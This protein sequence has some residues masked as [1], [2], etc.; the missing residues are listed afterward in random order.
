MHLFITK[1]ENYFTF[2]TTENSGSQPFKDESD[3]KVQL[4]YIKK[5]FGG[6]TVEIV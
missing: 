1:Y 4:D 5:T 3:F 2:R 6:T